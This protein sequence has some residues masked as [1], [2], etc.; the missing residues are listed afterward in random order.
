[1]LEGD[2]ISHLWGESEKRLNIS[3]K[4]EKNR[5]T[6]YGALDLLKPDLIVRPYPRGKVDFTREFL[7]ELMEINKNKQILIFWDGASYHR[8][9]I[10][11]D[12]W[13]VVNGNLLEEDWKVTC[14]LFAPYA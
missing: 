12:F 2:L 5:Q 3:R 1:M 6:Y 4:N 11:K 10:M 9:Q 7:K 8:G 13:Q 14:H